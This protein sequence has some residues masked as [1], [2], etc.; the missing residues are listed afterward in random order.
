MAASSLRSML[1]RG[2]PSSSESLPLAVLV[3]PLTAWA[4]M[5][6]GHAARAAPERV[7]AVGLL[8]P[9]T[10]LSLLSEFA[11]E[12]ATM[13]AILRPLDVSRQA[14]ALAPK[15]IFTIIGDEDPRV[16]T[17]SCV[18]M[19]RTVQVGT[20]PGKPMPLA[21]SVT[22]SPASAS[23]WCLMCCLLFAVPWLRCTRPSSARIQ[24]QWLPLHPRRH[25]ATGVPR[26]EGAHCCAV[27]GPGVDLCGTGGVGAARGRL[28]RGIPAQCLLP[29]LTACTTI[30]GD[31]GLFCAKMFS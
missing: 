24:L 26:A 31:L 28:I 9:V 11:A 19:M 12:N 15:N 6:T 18:S 20:S 17:D 30:C 4:R 3:S 2:S 10:N 14:A 16:F 13:Q 8:S 25:A 21:L 1:V 22:A 23:L 7:A 27:H 29:C 5:C